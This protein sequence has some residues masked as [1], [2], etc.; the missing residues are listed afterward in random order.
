MRSPPASPQA[1]HLDHPLPCCAT[2][3]NEL[4]ERVRLRMP[5]VDD[6]IYIEWLDPDSDLGWRYGLRPFDRVRRHQGRS[7]ELVGA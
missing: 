5:E 1:S 6:G 4:P 7:T 2:D 3:Y